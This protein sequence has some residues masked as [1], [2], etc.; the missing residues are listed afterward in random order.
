VSR[1]E[2]GMVGAVCCFLGVGL[3]LVVVVVDFPCLV[4]GDGADLD[5][6]FGLEKGV[7]WARPLVLFLG[8]DFRRLFLPMT[9][10]VMIFFPRFDL[11]YKQ[12]AHIILQLGLSYFF[13]EIWGKLQGWGQMGRFSSYRYIRHYNIVPL[14]LL[15]LQIK[16]SLHSHFLRVFG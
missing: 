6:P 8:L 10:F 1:G 3:L 9:S 15:Q 12:F 2:K 16:L 14:F 13:S 11:E 7:G 5:I 4:D